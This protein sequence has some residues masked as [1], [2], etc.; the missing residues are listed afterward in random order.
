MSSSLTNFFSSL[1]KFN[2]YFFNENLLFHLAI[3][4]N[5]EFFILLCD[6]KIV[7]IIYWNFTFICEKKFSSKEHYTFKKEKVLL[8]KSYLLF[9]E[10]NCYKKL[11]EVLIL[12]RKHHLAAKN[13][14]YMAPLIKFLTPKQS[15]RDIT[16]VEYNVN[17]SDIT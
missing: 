7:R 6:Q 15:W 13:I 17:K 8:F 11:N 3:I 5:G 4:K 1:R 2:I 10:I 9:C 14:C 12:L 16:C